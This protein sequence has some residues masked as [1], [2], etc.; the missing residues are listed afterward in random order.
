[1]TE[2]MGEPVQITLNGERRALPAP[3]S[4]HG[5]I[6]HLGLS[7]DAVAVERNLEIV[8]R[9]QWPGTVL[10]DGDRVEVVHFVGGG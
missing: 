6:E 5:L 2:A 1:M 9:H 7:A 10:R 4:V 3:T 8:R